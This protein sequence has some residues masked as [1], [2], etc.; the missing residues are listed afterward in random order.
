MSYQ[1]VINTMR[2][3]FMAYNYPVPETVP[4]AEADRK[5]VV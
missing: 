3:G 4:E 1:S 2:V 5:S